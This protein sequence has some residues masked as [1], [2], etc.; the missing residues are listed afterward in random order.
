MCVRVAANVLFLRAP[1][2]G[3][4]VRARPPYPSTSL[5]GASPKP[6]NRSN[7]RFSCALRAHVLACLCVKWRVLRWGYRSFLRGVIPAACRPFGRQRSRLTRARLRAVAR[8]RF[9][10]CR[11]FFHPCPGKNK[12]LMLSGALP[13]LTP[14]RVAPAGGRC[15]SWYLCGLWPCVGNFPPMKFSRF[16]DKGAT[17]KPL[18]R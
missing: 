11:S 10:G 5:V 8:G 18:V 1:V 15:F 12:C 16:S 3:T 14:A 6:R 13:P 4:Y 17:A 9:S 2:L 7:G